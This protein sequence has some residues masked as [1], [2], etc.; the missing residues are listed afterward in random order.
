M[1]L[2][3]L[4]ALL[5]LLS[6]LS[7]CVGGGGVPLPIDRLTLI[8][9][10][11][12]EFDRLSPAELE[13]R[14]QTLQQEIAG[15]EQTK[16]RSLR[17]ELNRKKLLIAYC[18]ERRG[19]FTDAERI[20]SEVAGTEYGSIAW[21]RIGQISEYVIED[22][23]K[24]AADSEAA[25]EQRLEAQEI[26]KLQ[27][28]RAIS[29]FER[30]AN[31]PINTRVLLRK[32][33]VASLQPSSWE[34]VDIRHY[35]YQRLDEHYRDRL[36]YRVFEF[37][38]KISGGTDKNFSYVLAIILIAVL[39]KLI[40]TPLSAAQ[41]RSMQ[42]MQRL[43]PQ[44]KKLQEKYKD[45]KQQLARAQMDLF[46]EAKISPFQSC[47]PMLIQM[48]ILIWVYYGI[49]H[50]VFRFEGVHFLYLHN[51]ANPDVLPI[52]ETLFPGPLLLLY[53]VSMYFSQKL[54]TTPAATR[55]QEQQQKLMAYMMPVLLVLILKGL[56]AAFILYWFLQN[57]LMTGH[58]YLIMRGTKVLVPEA[59]PAGPPPRPAGPPPE[60]LDKLTQGTRRSGQKKKRKH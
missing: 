51:L 42:A 38:V 41:F 45:D 44:I 52:G 33:P 46:K 12:E 25:A 10:Q 57:I 48:P 22:A 26:I 4:L 5:V 37:L 29:A 53:G 7:G 9:D 49:R 47:L 24:R 39:A 40:T 35:S 32:P 60:A 55:E 14:L 18:W 21:F 2:V 30:T 43:Q 31:F 36:S 8:R 34:V 13:T 3:R 16:D 54:I 58:Q 17:A 28:K 1:T 19:D 6:L 27:Q 11:F 23:K 15:L 20:Y 59:A 56:P 50:F